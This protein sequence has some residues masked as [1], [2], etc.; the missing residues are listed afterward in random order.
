[1]SRN[2]D[3]LPKNIILF[4]KDYIKLVSAFMINSI[5][6]LKISQIRSIYPKSYYK[7]EENIFKF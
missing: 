2:L 3:Y 1:M 7:W 5:L 4:T 6:S